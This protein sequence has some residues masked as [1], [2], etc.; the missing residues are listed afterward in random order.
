MPSGLRLTRLGSADD[1][2]EQV[3]RVHADLDVLAQP[4]LPGPLRASISA[5]L[6][7]SL[8]GLDAA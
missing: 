1:A 4:R 5:S 2:D 7:R 6:A 8:T 3:R